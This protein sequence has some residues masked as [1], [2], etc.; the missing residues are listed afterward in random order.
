MLVKNFPGTAKKELM[1][2]SAEFLQVLLCIAVCD[3][4]IIFESETKIRF[5]I[6]LLHS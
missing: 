6:K 4:I 5:L 2:Q 3:I 1:K